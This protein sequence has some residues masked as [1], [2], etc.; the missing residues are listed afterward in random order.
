MGIFGDDSWLGRNS[1]VI[2]D[3]LGLGTNLLDTNN[4]NQ[5]RDAYFDGIRGS[6]MDDYNRQKQAYDAEAAYINGPLAQ[7]EAAQAGA[8][9]SN[10]ASAAAAAAANDAAR[11]KAAKK[12]S[13]AER[14]GYTAAIKM[15]QPF[16]DMAYGILPGMTDIVSKYLGPEGARSMP[17]HQTNVPLPTDVKKKLGIG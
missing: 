15:Y 5:G 14:K 13:K 3:I 1:G 6:V 9:A 11:R 8:S 16:G 12:A 2:G 17:A 10:R 7:W 4:Q